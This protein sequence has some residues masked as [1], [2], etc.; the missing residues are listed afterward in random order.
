M[1][2]KNMEKNQERPGR[3]DGWENLSQAE[4]IRMA[5]E[6]VRELQSE[7]GKGGSI[8]LTYVAPGAQLIEH[9]DTQNVYQGGKADSEATGEADTETS[10]ESVGEACDPD[11]DGPHPPTLPTAEAMAHA[12]ENTMRAG[13]W[14]ANTAW[15]VVYR[16]YQMLGYRGGYSQFVRRVDCWPRSWPWKTACRYDAVQKPV[17]SGRLDGTPEEWEHRPGLRQAARLGKALLRELSPHTGSAP[18]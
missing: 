14:W 7:M 17:T 18:L 4:I 11:D 12:V 3:H 15:A 9:L 8:S 5:K 2:Q 16:V 13:Y 6:L 1:K 10:G